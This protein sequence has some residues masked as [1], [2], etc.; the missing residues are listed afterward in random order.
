MFV[1]H[2]VYAACIYVC[3]YVHVFMFAFVCMYYAFTYM[4][5]CVCMYVCMY[6]CICTN[7]NASKGSNIT[8]LRNS[9]LTKMPK[10]LHHYDV[11]IP[12]V[13]AK[14]VSKVTRVVYCMYVCTYV[15]MYV[16]LYDYMHTY[17]CVLY[18][19][20]IWYEWNTKAD[21]ERLQIV[22]MRFSHQVEGEA[23]GV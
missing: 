8:T 20:T 12:T 3:I 18:V 23:L 5:V 9:V 2:V 17:T 16:G 1:T 7:A 22:I 6:V 14:I 10:P 13:C 4:N 11:T 15:C 19:T 21:L